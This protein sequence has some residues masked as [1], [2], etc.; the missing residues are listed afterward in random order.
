[1]TEEQMQTKFIEENMHILHQYLL[2]KE[3]ILE[4]QVLDDS[5]EVPAENVDFE[6]IEKGKD[7]SV[8]QVNNGTS[9]KIEKIENYGKMD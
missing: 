4:P 6:V 1:M 3:T 9:G 2:W 8:I 7:I 5:V